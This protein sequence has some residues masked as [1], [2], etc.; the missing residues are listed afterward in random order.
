MRNITTK[1]IALKVILC[2]FLFV[3]TISFSQS[4]VDKVAKQMFIDMNN[5]DYD[6]ILEMSHPKVFELVSKDQM[7][8][9]LKSTIEGNEQF[10]IDIPK[11]IPE[12]KISKIYKEEEDNLQYAFVS[13]DMSMN[14]TFHDQKFDEEAKKIMASTM[15]AQ[16]MDTEFLSE[17]TVKIIMNDRITVILK[18]DSTKN[19]WVMM[20]YDTSSPL[21]YQVFSTSLLET[22]KKYREDL[23]LESKKK[24]EN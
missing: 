16:G 6:A 18:G 3:T 17:N 22:A 14:M 2:S 24:R 10:S 19:K 21:V 11:V 8:D 13:Y 4:E 23:L 5:R 9:F 1:T 7:K 15:K 12:Y 20:N